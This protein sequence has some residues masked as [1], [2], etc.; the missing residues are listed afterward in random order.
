MG[1]TV[2]S[3][4]VIVNDFAHISG[5]TAQVALSSARLGGSLAAL[6]RAVGRSP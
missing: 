2:P 4:V 5:G 1:K 6:D 3:H